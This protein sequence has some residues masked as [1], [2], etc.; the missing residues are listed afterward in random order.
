VYYTVL[1]E[2][3]VV[4]YNRAVRMG[5]TGSIVVGKAGRWVLNRSK[6]VDIDYEVIYALLKRGKRVV[7]SRFLRL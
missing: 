7:G 6:T 3:C 2:V 1:V 5:K 4:R